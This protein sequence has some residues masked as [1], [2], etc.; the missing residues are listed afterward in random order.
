[1]FQVVVLLRIFLGAAGK[2]RS[3]REKNEGG[4]WALGSGDR[5]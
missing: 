1:M 5:G 4:H 2:R 3:M